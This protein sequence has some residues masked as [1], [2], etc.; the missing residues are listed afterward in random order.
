M[1]KYFTAITRSVI[2]CLLLTLSIGFCYAFSLFVPDLSN[3]LNCSLN[4]I[5]FSFCINIFFLGMGAAFFGTLVEKKIKLASFISTLFLFIGLILTGL[6]VKY[7]SLILLYIGFGLFCGLSEGCGYVTPVKNLLLW[8]KNTNKKG[9]ISAISIISFGLGSTICSYLFKVIS[10]N[11]DF[12]YIFYIFAVIYLIPTLIA[13]IL[14]Q[15]PEEE[16]KEIKNFV[17]IK[18]KDLIKDSFFIKSWIFMFLNISMGLILIGTCQS[19]LSDISL[20]NNTIIFIMMLCGLFNG[21]GRLVFPFISDFLKSR[22][23]IWIITLI[24]E[25]S[26]MIIPMI[27]YAF[28]PISIILIN[29]TYGSAFA[30]LPSVLNDKY[31]KSNLSQ[32]HG[33]VLSAWGIAS[34]FA[35]ICTFAV[36]AISSN[37]YFLSYLLFAIYLI[38]FFIV[39][40][41]KKEFHSK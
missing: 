15:K 28:I 11:F 7:Q 25:C 4:L 18:I 26:V 22:I 23:N 8:W 34:I 35:F 40:S 27:S 37:Y 19:I 10:N 9:L 29:A 21:A 3:S 20:N 2:P 39:V 33:Y 31:G 1:K 24:I 12:K 32:I 5:R 38:N 41:I 16:Q 13:T 6:S 36:T 17:S 14:I 30:T